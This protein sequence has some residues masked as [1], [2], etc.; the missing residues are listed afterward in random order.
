MQHLPIPPFT[1]D[2]ALAKVQAIQDEWNTGD[3]ET[4]AQSFSPDGVWRHREEVFKGRA[5]IK[6]L[7]NRRRI[8]ATHSQP[9]REIW[10]FTSNRISVRF[11]YEWQH[12][13]TGQ[14]FRS[15]GNEHWEFNADGL[16]T[17]RDAS[18]N[19]ILISAVEQRIGR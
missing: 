13:K 14:W 19:D 3:P 2:T 11:E 16:I 6:F 5:A 1:A 18:V 8:T 17:K 4:V 12:T 9:D 15:H 10:A 7:V